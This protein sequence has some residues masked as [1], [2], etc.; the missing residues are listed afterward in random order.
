MDPIVKRTI[1]EMLSDRGYN[2]IEDETEISIIAKNS[3]NV[4]LIVYY[5]IDPKVSVKKIKDIKDL[6]DTDILG[7]QTLIL[8]YR[9]SITSFA[10]QFIVTDMNVYV[11]A[12]SEKE[13]KFNVTKHEY[14]PKH[15]IISGSEKDSLLK[16]YKISMRQLP[17][18]MASDPVARYFGAKPGVVFK[19]TRNSP[20]V[21]M[22]LSYRVVV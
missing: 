18:I 6:M 22:Y 2:T 15:E 7:Y 4:R 1:H 10:K 19:I 9:T 13:L 16:Q 8:V 17:C 12:F 14:V 5:V 20:N 3:Q 21:G 11:Q